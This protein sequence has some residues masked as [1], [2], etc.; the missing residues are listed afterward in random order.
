MGRCTGWGGRSY[1]GLCYSCRGEGSGVRPLG[2]MPLRKRK[3][4]GYQG[5]SS[6]NVSLCSDCDMAGTGHLELWDC[7]HCSVIVCAE[8]THQGMTP[9]YRMARGSKKILQKEKVTAPGIVFVLLHCLYGGH[10][11]LQ[12]RPSAHNSG[13]CRGET[14]L[15]VCC[16]DTVGFDW[17]PLLSLGPLFYCKLLCTCA[18]F[19]HRSSKRANKDEIISKIILLLSFRIF[20]R[21][22]AVLF[23]NPS[24]SFC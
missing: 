18:N 2:A 5:G 23:Q 7:T 4:R 10:C 22:W 3:R 12:K 16:A 6:Q 15:G 11:W 17:E 19:P 13:P 24:K 21:P 9:L 20:T 8:P 14:R 1:F